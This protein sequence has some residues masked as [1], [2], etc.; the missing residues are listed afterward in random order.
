MSDTI[1]VI[2]KAKDEVSQ[3]VGGIRG[4][5]SGLTSAFGPLA[6][7]GR[8]ALLG[9]G[10]AAAGGFGLAMSSAINMNSSL[11]QSTMQFTTLMGDADMAAAHVAALFDF[12]ASTPYE[13]E[14]IITASKH[15]QIFGGEALNTMDNMTLVGDA[16]AAVGAPIDEVSF[17]IGR[18]YSNLM[19]GQPFGE[20]AMRLQELGIMAPT[21]RT[22][23]E[24]LQDTGATGAEVW[25]TFQDSLGN[26]TG[27]ME[28]QSQSW[29]GF[30]STIK[31]QLGLLSAEALRPFFDLAKQGLGELAEWLSSPEVQAG[32]EQLATGFG[33]LITKVTEF[34]TGT[35]L[36]ALR[37]MFTDFR[38]NIL[39]PL[40]EKFLEIKAAV[41][42][43]IAPIA[44]AVLNFITFKDVLIAL[45]LAIMATVL[46]AIISLVVSM[47]PILLAI[48]AVIAVV[49]LL[50]TAWEENWGGI[51]EKVE[52]VINFIKPLID[53]ALAAIQGFW[54]T[55]GAAITAV[56]ESAW[57]AIQAFI[58]AV[59]ITI[60]TIIGGALDAIRGFWEQHGEAISSVAQQAWELIKNL[61]DGVLKTIKSL[62]DAFRALFEGD[63]EEFG[64]K[65]QELWE[66]AWNTI[67]NFLSGLWDMI[68]PWLTKVWNDIKG[69]F[70][71]TDWK[72][73]GRNIIDGIVNGLNAAGAAIKEKIMSF[74][75]AAWDA[76]K[77]FFGIS[78][79]SR[80]MYWA[81]QMI[82]QG[83]I[84][85][86]QSKAGELES[87]LGEILSKA[88]NVANL[89]SSFGGVF[90]RQVL[91]PIAGQIT[92]L[93]NEL[94]NVDNALSGMLGTLGLDIASGSLFA[95]L[96]RII[97]TGSQ[98]ER[99][100]AMNAIA[101][102]EERVRLMGQLT[103][104]QEAYAGQEARLLILEQQRAQLGFLQ[105]QFE[106]LKLIKD[107][108]LSVSLLEG[109]E[110][111]LN[112]DPGALMDAMIAALQ[113][114]IAAA[115]EELGIHS[116][117]KWAQDTMSNVMETMAATVRKGA[118][119]V[120]GG[121]S[122]APER[123]M[124]S[125]GGA[126]VTTHNMTVNVDARGAERGAE[127][128]IRR[129]VESVLREYGI[130]AD[131]RM[132]TAR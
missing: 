117:S 1:E 95:N 67:T 92:G 113:A 85:G 86:I 34:V 28:M 91:D 12:A 112:A 32:I 115:E 17:W 105:Q 31:D 80:L 49:A 13:T 41:D 6:A 51:Q 62:F 19:A 33:Q 130:R 66:N 26:F 110:L 104:M 125:S 48:G 75:T 25:G 103:H 64:N 76:V 124:V 81:G 9:V 47:A 53:G 83:L 4:S 40:R 101:F 68:L 70:T 111:G 100:I 79:P 43:F 59:V 44:D 10:A 2:I 23:L 60:Q 123:V 57:G 98:E 39:P 45:G 84:D 38:D 42:E 77:A 114:M 46:P 36:P 24:D 3:T 15:L 54:D 122:L 128:D 88:G 89:G 109:L 87:V 126:G 120:R 93:E 8:G 56:V 35:A 121:L 27:A 16:A 90:Q 72:S 52:A 108:N 96:Q 127:R 29:T 22:A 94:G 82:G 132:R 106:L 11:E 107:N 74:V 58:S 118:A 131:I 61:I 5:L 21:T 18:L 116:P 71:R 55:H 78:S 119:W 65:L 129:A 7:I 73:L 63:W 102:L 99:I 50:R 20:A 69:W 37:E 30:V 97:A 14:P